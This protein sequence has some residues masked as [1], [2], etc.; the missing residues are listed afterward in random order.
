MAKKKKRYR[1]LDPFDAFVNAWGFHSA[2]TVLDKRK[3]TNVF[4]YPVMVNGAFALEL[5]IKCVH[6]VRRR[7]SKKKT[8]GHE[9]PMLFNNLSKS[10][11]SRI[12]YHLDR[13]L[14][15]H[16]LTVQMIESGILLDIDSILARADGMFDRQR[17]WHEHPP[18]GR[19]ASGRAASAGVE[20]L[21]NAL[22]LFLLELRPEWNE[23]FCQFTQNDTPFSH[24]Q[25]PT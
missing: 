7:R 9:L 18:F 5:Y 13:V 6:Y 19:D 17:Y 21:T 8:F 24:I 2:A 16:P 15:K 25:L 3:E 11:K 14:E 1:P 12:Q 10:D 23:R 20:P 4:A 22:M